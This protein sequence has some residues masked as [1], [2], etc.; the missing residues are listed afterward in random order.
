LDPASLIIVADVDARDLL[1]FPT[2]RSSDLS[3]PEKERILKESFDNA[4]ELM[5][6]PL[7]NNFEETFRSFFVD[8]IKRT[9]HQIRL[10]FRTFTPRN[11]Y[12]AIRPLL[13][14]YG[15]EKDLIEAG[16]GMSNLILLS[17]FRTYAKVFKDDAFIA[18]EE[19]EIY[20]HPHAR[21][22]L[23][24]LFTDLAE[25]GSQIFYS[26]HSEDF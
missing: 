13:I 21:R 18:I 5:R 7:F 10:D 12:L 6:T 24:T 4:L 17:L 3:T 26:T 2:R 25:Q 22:S 16:Q 8:Q 23:Y 9:T 20:L 19:P 15:L 11:Y 14:E 1:S